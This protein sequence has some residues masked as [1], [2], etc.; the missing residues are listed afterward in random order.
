M[1]TY[2]NL[3]DT[4]IGDF[5]LNKAALDAILGTNS[6]G[7]VNTAI[8][9]VGAGVLSGAGIVGGIITRG[10]TQTGAFTDTSDTVANIIAA[11]G[12][13]GN[14]GNTLSFTYLNNA[15]F[16]AT[17][18]AGTGVTL[19]GATI[20]PANSW[21]KYLLTL[22]GSGAVS[23][24]GVEQGYF[25]HSGTFVANGAT[26]VTVADANLTA[27]SNVTITLKTVGGTVGAIPAVKTVT[28]QTG[29]T[30]AGTA[31]DTSTYAYEIRG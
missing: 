31:L 18:A 20:V 10:G 15:I 25:P 26:P 8:N 29:F 4:S 3:L 30:V 9:T 12:F 17:I 7:I 24:V 5:V 21:V 11:G 19:T 2:Y 1:R 13:S 14:I 27:N 16:P 22:T 6:S 28:P 23:M